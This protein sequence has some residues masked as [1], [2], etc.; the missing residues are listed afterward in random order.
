MVTAVASCGDSLQTAQGLSYRATACGEQRP[1][2]D[3]LPG[4]AATAEKTADEASKDLLAQIAAAVPPGFIDDQVT[5]G[6]RRTPG[7]V[8]E[9]FTPQQLQAWRQPLPWA[10]WPLADLSHDPHLFAMH[11][12]RGRGGPERV[13]TDKRA[14]N[15][16]IPRLVHQMDIFSQDASSHASL[17]AWA[18]FAA[19]FAYQ[20]KIWRAADIDSLSRSLPPAHQQLLAAARA[21]RDQREVENLLSVSVLARQGGIWVGRLLLPPRQGKVAIDLAALAPMRNLVVVSQHAS[22]AV[23]GTTLWASMDLIMATPEHP[24]MRHLEAIAPQNSAAWRSHFAQHSAYTSGSVFFSRAL[25]GPIT[26]LPARFLS[27]FGLL[28]ADEPDP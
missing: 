20:H 12:P 19:T 22:R 1:Q 3:I 10:A 5:R 4:E 2:K 13:A 14:I 26:V 21:R 27:R 24:S 28:V 11:A 18:E 7:S 23:G 16:P 6:V 15:R 9:A 25:A 8:G 17:A